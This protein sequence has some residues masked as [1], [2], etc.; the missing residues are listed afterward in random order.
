MPIVLSIWSLPIAT[1]ED[2]CFHVQSTGQLLFLLMPLMS[3]TAKDYLVIKKPIGSHL[4]YDKFI[5]IYL[6]ASPFQE[7]NNGNVH[8]PVNNSI[9]S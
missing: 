1:I 9:H 4:F 8:L 6:I 3:K 5:I 7:N 2:H